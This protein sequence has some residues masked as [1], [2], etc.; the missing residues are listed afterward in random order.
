MNDEALLALAADLAVRAGDRIMRIRAAG[1]ETRTKADD[2]PVTEADHEAE[3]II[4]LGLRAALPGALIVAEEECAA[5]GAPGAQAECWLVDPL[6]GTREFA[7]GRPE[8]TVNIAL[9]RAGAPVLGVVLAP[10]LGELF[11]AVCGRAFKRTEAGERPIRVRAAPA[12]GIAVATSR[13]SGGDA[14]VAA[15]L[16]GRRVA[17]RMHYGSSLKFCRVAEGAADAYPRF[18]RTMEWDTAAGQAVLEAAGGSVR[19]MAGARLRYGK[20]GWENPDFVAE[21]KS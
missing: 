21:A 12:E 8:F 15:W 18:G 3:A 14:R 10:A 1:F 13:R 17:A 5:L 2:S 20:P 19:T 6:D 4:A 7:A 16:E 9:V 11:A